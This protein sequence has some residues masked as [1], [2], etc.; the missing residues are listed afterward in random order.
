MKKMLSLLLVLSMLLTAAAA[1]AEEDNTFT[2]AC[3]RW[4]EVWGT[5]FTE[6]AFLNNPFIMPFS[7][8]P[9]NHC[10]IISCIVIKPVFCSFQDTVYHT[11]GDKKGTNGGK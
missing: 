6:T 4:T 2:V 9:M 7:F 3:V 8:L 10:L 5:D 1:F 11:K